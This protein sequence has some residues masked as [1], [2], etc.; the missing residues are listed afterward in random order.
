[1]LP[2]P[3][4]C[5]SCGTPIH[6]R[7][8]PNRKYCSLRCVGEAKRRLGARRC[9]VCDKEFTPSRSTQTTCSQACGHALQRT[10]TVVPWQDRLWGQ[11]DKTASCWLWTGH[12]NDKGYGTLHVDSERGIQYVHR[13]SWELANG[14]IPDGLFVC[15][16]C[17]GGDNPACLNPNHLF[18]G[19]NRDNI[20]DAKAKGRLATGDRHGTRL[21]PERGWW[22][23]RK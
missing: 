8:H 18:L 10:M 7:K 13:L 19:T 11:T 2:Q 23:T 12:T 20:L 9:V 14:P 22:N 3:T 6:D 5:A 17:P 16:D 15:H 21:H 4:T 1:M